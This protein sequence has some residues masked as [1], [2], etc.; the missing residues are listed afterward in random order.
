MNSPLQAGKALDNDKKVY[1]SLGGLP[2][3]FTLE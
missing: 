2:L 3:S 1:V